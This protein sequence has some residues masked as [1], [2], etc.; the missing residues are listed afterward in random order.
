M[1]DEIDHRED[2]LE[3]PIPETMQ[4]QI[5]RIEHIL[6]EIWPESRGGGNL[7][8]RYLDSI[9]PT[10]FVCKTPVSVVECVHSP[11]TNTNIFIAKCHGDQEIVTLDCETSIFHTITP[12]YAFIKNHVEK[13]DGVCAEH[14]GGESE[15]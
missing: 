15:R 4:D 8:D 3:M 5:A 13:L 10:C 11:S 12:G 2:K 1:C 14:K 7:N 6:A 9:K